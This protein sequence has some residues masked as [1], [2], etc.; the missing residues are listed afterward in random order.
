MKWNEFVDEVNE[1]LEDEGIDDPTI[2]Y[3]DIGGGG[4][5]G[6]ELTDISIAIND[7]QISIL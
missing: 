4:Q 3:I 7:G 6:V 1:Y 5:Y 2:E